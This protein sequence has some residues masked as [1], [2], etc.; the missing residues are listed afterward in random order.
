VF[1][2]GNPWLKTSI[3]P[4]GFEPAPCRRGDRTTLQVV[5]IISVAVS[6]ENSPLFDIII[7]P[8]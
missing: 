1:L 3:G 7:Y 8:A 6:F 4:A 5:E 2:C